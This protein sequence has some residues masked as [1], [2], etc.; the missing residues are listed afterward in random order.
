[1]QHIHNR[2]AEKKDHMEFYNGHT[3]REYVSFI[4]LSATK[5]NG[6]VSD[7]Q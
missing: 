3:N 4:G 7:I 5:K 6:G 2:D 1:M